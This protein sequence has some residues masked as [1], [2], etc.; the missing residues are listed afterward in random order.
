MDFRFTFR[1]LGLRATDYLR[2]IA[3][4]LVG[5]AVMAAVVLLVQHLMRDV[6]TA[7]PRFAATVA[8]GALAYGMVVVLGYRGRIDAFRAALRTRP[9]ASLSR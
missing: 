6:A 5:S 9:A 4:P 7:T 2:A 1:L 3:A 8:A